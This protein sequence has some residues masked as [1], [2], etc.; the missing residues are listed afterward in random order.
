MSCGT[1]F[2]PKKKTSRCVE[3]TL[4]RGH[5]VS[6]VEA[7]LRSIQMIKDEEDVSNFLFG[8]L[9][10]VSDTEHVPVKIYFSKGG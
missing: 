4:N 2:L 1:K 6:A 9:F 3:M 7:Y 5:I 10:G 8:E